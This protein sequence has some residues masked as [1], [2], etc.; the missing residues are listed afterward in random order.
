MAALEKPSWAEY[1]PLPVVPGL[2]LKV[3]AELLVEL[4]DVQVQ[5]EEVLDVEIVAGELVQVEV[6]PVPW[7][8]AWAQAHVLFCFVSVWPSQ[9]SRVSHTWASG[10]EDCAIGGKTYI[11]IPSNFAMLSERDI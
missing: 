6:L 11:K 3:L 4:E 1:H 2:L 7:E 5:V 9:P 8:D 10:C